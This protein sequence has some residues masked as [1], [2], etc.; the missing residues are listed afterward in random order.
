MNYTLEHYRNWDYGCL[1]KTGH[2]AATA[3]VDSGGLFIFYNKEQAAKGCEDSSS[4]CF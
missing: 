2:G 3:R 1:P 4:L